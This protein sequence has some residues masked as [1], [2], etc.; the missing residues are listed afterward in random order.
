MVKKGELKMQA[1]PT[2][3]LKT[4]GEKMSALATPTMFMKTSNLILYTYDIYENKGSCAPGLA[5][6]NAPKDRR[7]RPKSAT[8]VPHC[9]QGDQKGI[10]L[11]TFE[12]GMCMKT[13]DRKTQCPNKNR[14]IVPRFRHFRQIERYCAENCCF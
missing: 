5:A 8:P 1:T 4:H 6:P 14:L 3:L 12:A 10:L 7:R 2:M 11:Y 9:R 13:K